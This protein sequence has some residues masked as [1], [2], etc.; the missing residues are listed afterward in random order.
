MVEWGIMDFMVRYPLPAGYSENNL[1]TYRVR[2][3]PSASGFKD[4]D[5]V[6]T[7]VNISA[8]FQ[9]NVFQADKSQPARKVML[10]NVRKG[11]I[12]PADS[13]PADAHDGYE[14]NLSD[15]DS[16]E[17]SARKSMENLQYFIDA[18]P[19]VQVY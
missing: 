9:M 1:F 6:P 17:L 4:R 5:N 11:D 19:F 3:E 15:S 18:L 14:V 8:Y 2:V 13:W 16:G 7:K 12:P 10:I